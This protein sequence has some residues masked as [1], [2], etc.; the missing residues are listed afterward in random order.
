MKGS[1]K[2]AEEESVLDLPNDIGRLL[3]AGLAQLNDAVVVASI[4][5]DL[6][7]RA[8]LR[9]RS[10]GAGHAPLWEEPSRK[11]PT[12]EV[13]YVNAAFER[14]TGWTAREV[15]GRPLSML[16]GPGTSEDA[17]RSLRAAALTQ[18]TA[19]AELLQYARDGREFW[20]DVSVTA[21]GDEAG[22]LTHTITIF[23]DIT[24][25][26]RLEEQLLQAQ[27]LD[28]IGRLAG[29]IAHDFN[30]VL[31]AISGFSELLLDDVAAG[32]HAHEELLQ[33]R[34]ASD[35]AVALT[36]QLLAFSRK[37]FLRPRHLDIN[38]HIRDMEQLLRRVISAQVHIR[39]V[40]EEP[41]PAVYADPV[42]FEQV[43]L[44]L[45]INAS[46]A[47]PAGGMLTI[48]SRV[49]TL[50][51]GFGPRSAGVAPARYV[52]LAVTDTGAGMD[53]HTREQIFE[54]FFTTKR[55]GTGLGLSTVNEIVTRAGGQI[56]VRSDVGV[57]TTF[58]VALPISGAR[59]DEPAMLAHV[60]VT[61]G[62]ETV[63]VVEDDPTV[64]EVVRAM[65]Q[66]RGYA[67]LLAGDG[68]EA[69]RLV[70]A[71][72]GRVHLLLTDVV[73]PM[74]SGAQVAQR[75]SLLCPGLRV[76]Y[77]TGYAEDAIFPSL[78]P[79]T[80]GDML[81]KPFADL[82]LARRVRAALDTAEALC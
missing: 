49:M 62:R 24:E 26:R 28:A 19:R 71:H 53:R 3:R 63:L 81:T 68:D 31:T 60:D 12:T 20:S 48:E 58:E 6:H 23:R 61:G 25:R 22:A 59:I 80:D 64:R 52:C 77:M 37:Q 70:T 11:F 40:L 78:R 7:A 10:P 56:A 43:L 65:L 16:D 13:C 51:A 33:I 42:Q 4:R 73:L 5:P 57:G 36:R 38:T 50:G 8:E 74:Q 46:E 54:P 1:I 44:N 29:G 14:L 41:L 21:V 32:S 82:T 30:N 79:Q 69:A 72:D 35:R 27:K 75:V 39:T 9:V 17:L 76:L 45:V 66:R 55:A 2:V 18:S 34:S 15:T 47:M 67:V